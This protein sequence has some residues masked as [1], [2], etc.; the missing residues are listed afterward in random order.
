MLII[1]KIEEWRGVKSLKWE[2]KHFEPG[3]NAKLKEEKL[4]A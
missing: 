3:P 2:I 4:P 1:P